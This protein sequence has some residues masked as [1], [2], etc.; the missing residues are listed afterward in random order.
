MFKNS[1]GYIFIL[2]KNTLQAL[3]EINNAIIQTLQFMYTVTQN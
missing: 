3:K 1:K 2:L